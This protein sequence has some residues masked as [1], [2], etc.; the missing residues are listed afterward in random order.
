[1]ASAPSYRLELRLARLLAP[2]VSPVGVSTASSVTSA[3]VKARHGRIITSFIRNALCGVV[4]VLDVARVGW[5]GVGPCGYRWG[6]HERGCPRLR[7]G[8]L[9]RL[10]D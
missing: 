5:K 7:T 8:R 3:T 6:M 4:W 9:L 1:M 2:L 10:Y